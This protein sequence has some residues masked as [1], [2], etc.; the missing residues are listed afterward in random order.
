MGEFKLIHVIGDSHAESFKGQRE[1]RVH[2]IGRATAYNLIKDNSTTNSKQKTLNVMS[3]IP[4]GDTVAFVLGEIDCRVH[5]YQKYL[6]KDKI[7]SL[8]TLI[9][10]TINRYISFLTQFKEHRIVAVTIPPAGYEGN[11]FKYPFYGSPEIRAYINQTYNEK[12]IEACKKEKLSYVDIYDK[13]VLP[14]GLANTRYLRD[15]IHLNH[16][17]IRL[18]ITELNSLE[19][20]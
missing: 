1:V 4:K 17:A 13:I 8:E 18:I 7:I 11:E 16:S 3:K 15:K 9:D 5:I 19:T 12:L 6:V 20:K 2:V 14:N 10:N